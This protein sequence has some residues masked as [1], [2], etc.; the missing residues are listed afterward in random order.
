MENIEPFMTMPEVDG[1]LV[2]GA[3]LTVRFRGA[4]ATSGCMKRYKAPV[5]TSAAAISLLLALLPPLVVLFFDRGTT[6]I[7]EPDKL[8]LFRALI[9]LLVGWQLSLWVLKLQPPP[10]RWPLIWPA[11]ALLGTTVLATFSSIAPRW[12]T[13]GSYERGQGLLTLLALVIYAYLV[14]RY[15]AVRPLNEWIPKATVLGSAVVV[16]YALAQALDADPF[17]WQVEPGSFPVFGT[18][19]RSNYLASFLV[20]V[21]PLTVGW[22]L[23]CRER[24]KR[25]ALSGLLLAQGLA[26]LLARSRGG[27][28]ALGAAIPVA[29]VVW[30][31]LHRARR[32][33]I[34]GVSL[35]VL[36]ILLLLALNLGGGPQRPVPVALAGTA[37]IVARDRRRVHGRAIDDTGAPHCAR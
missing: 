11:L 7:F 8:A 2:G 32:W 27:W 13:W 34:A 10:Q 1:A 37:G 16:L 24:G 26:L 20:M 6:T 21:I 31:L 30:G 36:G 9:L 12:S 4:S 15:R 18:L 23:T 17:T 14:Y 3:S 29:L 25:W 28:L 33:L 19:G 5:W 22:L 35:A